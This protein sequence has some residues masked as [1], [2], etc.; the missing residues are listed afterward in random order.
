LLP[1]ESGYLRKP[2]TK[3]LTE[4]KRASLDGMG[5]QCAVEHMLKVTGRR[6]YNEAELVMKVRLTINQDI[7]LRRSS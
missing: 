6:F 3:E 1:N 7:T 4:S 2:V 5:R